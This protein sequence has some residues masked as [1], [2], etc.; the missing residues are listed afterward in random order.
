M[1]LTTN[2][3]T[4]TFRCRHATKEDR[5]Y[6][7]AA[8]RAGIKTLGFADH[9]PMIFSQEGFVSGFRIQPEEYEGYVKSVTDLKKE[10]RDDITIHLGVELEYYPLCFEKTLAFLCEYPI[11]YTIMGQHHIHNEQDNYEKRDYCGK[12]NDDPAFL[13]TYVDQ[14][15]AGLATGAFTYFAH[16]DVI[17]FTGDEAFY[18]REMT[19]LLT[20]VKDL[21][22]PVEFNFLGYREHRHYPNPMVWQLVREIGNT[23]VIGLDAHTPET[24]LMKDEIEDMEAHL[25]SL[26]LTPLREIPLRDPHL[27]LKNI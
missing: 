20:G 1:N 12:E 21:G 9:S 19:R 8:I 24:Y 7:E 16:P 5:D 14:S 4:H 10:Y 18:R 11:E 15:L 6:V 3:H 13:T 17:H 23:V 2:L 25:A 22:I 26:G 27:A